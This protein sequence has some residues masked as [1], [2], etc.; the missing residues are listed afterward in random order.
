[1][2]TVSVSLVVFLHGLVLACGGGNG[3]QGPLPPPPPSPPVEL[4]FGAAEG[5]WHGTLL[6]P[7]GREGRAYLVLPESA[8]EGRP[9]GSLTVRLVP[10]PKCTG[11]LINAS[12]GGGSWG[13]VAAGDGDACPPQAVELA[14]DAGTDR[15]ELKYG[16]SRLTGTLT[17]SETL[18]FEALLGTWGGAGDDGVDEFFTRATFSDGTVYQGDVAATWELW[19][20]GLD[21]ATD[22]PTCT[23]DWVAQQVAHPDYELEEWVDPGSCV[24]GIVALSLAG[25]TLTYDFVSF[26]GTFP[27]TI[28]MT[29]Q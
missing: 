20:I 22:P 1:M 26:A 17:R 21:P 5:H 14:Y 19:D 27:A 23:G 12:G 11:A 6:Y 24:N 8:V 7:D 10:P 29:R 4:Q 25:S 13:L 15:L 3:V 28:D 2:R 18:S 16:D 9:A